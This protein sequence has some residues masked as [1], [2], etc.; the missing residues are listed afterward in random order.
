MILGEILALLSITKKFKM[1]LGDKTIQGDIVEIIDGELTKT[2]PYFNSKIL[3]NFFSKSDVID[4]VEKIRNGEDYDSQLSDSLE[5]FLKSQS[6]TV[7]DPLQM[8]RTFI[9]EIEARIVA[10]SDAMSKL[11]Y[12]YLKDISQKLDSKESHND[13]DLKEIFEYLKKIDGK[14]T[15]DPIPS[16]NQ[17]FKEIILQ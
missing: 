9:E 14:I 4:I 7:E 10:K 11:Q 16:K 17:Y 15:T 6:L 8:L 1:M 13:K 2:Y 12:K 5:F 3:I